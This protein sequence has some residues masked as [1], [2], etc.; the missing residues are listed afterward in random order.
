MLR[1]SLR[2][3]AWYPEAAAAAPAGVVV[4]GM[5]ATPAVGCLEGLDLPVIA[6]RRA[7]RSQRW[8]DGGR[9][10][11]RDKGDTGPLLEEASGEQCCTGVTD[12]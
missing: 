7:D 6:G 11:G 5:A 8:A 3:V 2:R 1:A 10:C 12:L 9:T 4:E